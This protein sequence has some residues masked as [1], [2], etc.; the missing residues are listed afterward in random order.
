MDKGMI[1]IET[2]E[3]PLSFYRAAPKTKAKGG[4]IL[5]HE[6]WGL[7]DHIKD[8]ADRFSSAGY[9]VVAPDLLAGTEL[10]SLITPKL[11]KKFIDPEKRS[12][13]QVEF[14]KIMGPLQSPEFSKRTIE[15]LKSL[16]SWLS[17]QPETD[18]KV[19]VLGFCFG[20]T[21][22]YALAVAEPTLVAAVPFYGHSDQ[23]VESLKR[24]SC[25]ILAFYGENDDNL[26]GKLP[27]VI[28][29]TSSAGVKFKHKVYPGAGHAFFND[30]NP[31]TYNKDAAEDSWKLTIKFLDENFKKASEVKI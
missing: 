6:V 17:K 26:I 24:V 5:I 25:P 13:M 15:R 30:R 14:R 16:F 22:S 29:R 9:Y 11:F 8:V 3:G 12:A 31:T 7:D 18:G 27:E 21:Y 20:G 1:D 23:D 2:S 28:E 10:E 19:A 4:I